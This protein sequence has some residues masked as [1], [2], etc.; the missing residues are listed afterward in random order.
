MRIVVAVS[1]SPDLLFTPQ[2][3]AHGYL[4]TWIRQVAAPS[5]FEHPAETKLAFWDGA[6]IY[7]LSLRGTLARLLDG[8]PYQ[9][10]FV[11]ILRATQLALVCELVAAD[12]MVT[13]SFFVES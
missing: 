11:L 13:F 2:G 7:N 9:A 8:T 12:P 6:N 1:F 10:H 4:V 5:L 3:G